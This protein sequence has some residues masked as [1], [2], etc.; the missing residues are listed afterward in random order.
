M[1]CSANVSIKTLMLSIM[2][3]GVMV[4]AHLLTTRAW[5]EPKPDKK[6]QPAQ[7]PTAR[8]HAEATFINTADL[9]VPGQQI[10]G[11]NSFGDEKFWGDALLLHQAIE[12]A[13]FWG[14]GPG[15]CP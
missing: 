3:T 2:I 4:S 15:I 6:K 13:N 11:F 8:A 10:F 12:G 7:M 14:V 5:A 1:K 9:V